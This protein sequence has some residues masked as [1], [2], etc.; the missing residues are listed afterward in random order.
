VDAH[1]DRIAPGA[2]LVMKSF[3]RGRINAVTV[4]RSGKG[5]SP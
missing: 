2:A 3:G 5:V 1:Q 4:K